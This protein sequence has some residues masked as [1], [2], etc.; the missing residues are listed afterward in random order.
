[1]LS[2]SL[3][4]YLEE[5]YRFSLYNDIVRVTDI[6]KCLDVTMPSVSNA[7]RR[8]SRKGYL[9]YRKYEDLVLTDKGERLGRFL[10]ERNQI[11]QDFFLLIESKCDVAKEA[12]A[13]EHYLSLP[14]IRAIQHLIDFLQIHT[15][16]YERFLNH[17]KCREEHGLG[18]ID[19]Y[20]G[21]PEK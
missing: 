1:M 5:I 18:I 20:N 3:E 9:V 8:L 12:E 15:D 21:K 4:D 2:P 11:L 17:Y 16:S 10:V 14:T 7:I 13:M 19:G 6:A